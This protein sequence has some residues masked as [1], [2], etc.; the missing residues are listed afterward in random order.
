MASTWKASAFTQLLSA[1]PRL[2]PTSVPAVYLLSFLSGS[3]VRKSSDLFESSD[4]LAA[5]ACS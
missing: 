2:Q 1:A 3:S 5:R 4:L